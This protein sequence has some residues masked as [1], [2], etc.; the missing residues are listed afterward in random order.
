MGWPTGFEWFIM[1]AMRSAIQISSLFLC[2]AAFGMALLSSCSDTTSTSESTSCLE[3]RRA[4]W[5]YE[6]GDPHA[7]IEGEV[8]NAC[9]MT[10]PSA[11]VEFNLLDDSGAQVG[12]VSGSTSNLPDQTVWKFHAYTFGQGKRA[13]TFK[14]TRIVGYK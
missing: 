7:T 14:M 8:F 2:I 5:V 4:D 9:G 3:L 1:G 11:I 6:A 10:I 13:S 12:S